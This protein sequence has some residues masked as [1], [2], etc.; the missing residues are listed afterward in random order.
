M[1]FLGTGAAEL[2]PNPFCGC[3]LCQEARKRPEFSRTRSCFQY[4]AQTMIDFGPDALAACHKFSVSLEN[5]HDILFT[6][7]HEDHFCV[8]NMDVIT[9]SSTSDDKPFTAHVSREGWEFILLQRK[10]VLDATGGNINLLAAV[11]KGWYGFQPHDA[12]ETFHLGEKTVFTVRG[13]HQGVGYNERSLHYRITENGK[14][15]LYALDGG[16][17]G[18]ESLEALSGVKLD[19]LILDATFGSAP[20]DENSGH[21]NGAHFLKQM[22]RLSKVGAVT[23][24]TRVYATHINHKHDWNHEA[25]QRFFTDSGAKNVTVARDGLE[26]AF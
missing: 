17:Y 11:D 10:A 5:L 24:G 21:L 16:L 6:H 15:L 25:Y 23:D 2:L 13:N 7:L 9:M 4:D 22:E 14:T 26:I 1:R 3:P 19:I 20:L 18:P 8:A 12:F